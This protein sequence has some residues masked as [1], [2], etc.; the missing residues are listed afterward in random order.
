[1]MI[2]D[3]FELPKLPRR[4]RESAITAAIDDGI[5]FTA[6]R[7]AVELNAD[8]LDFVKFGWGS[9]LITK[10]LGQKI[11]VLKSNGIGFCVGG[12]M[13]E[14]AFFQGKLEP[15]IDWMDSIDATHFEISDGTIEIGKARK[16][17]LIRT[18]SGR[19][20]VL[21]EVGSKDAENVMTPSEYIREIGENSEAGCWKIILE[22][23][24]NGTVGIYD[25]TGKIKHD[26]LTVL[27][28]ATDIEQI[29]FEAPGVTQQAQLIEHFSEQ[30]NL[31]N[32]PL[33][34]TLNTQALRLGLR[35]DTFFLN[36]PFRR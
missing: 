27:G 30:V 18:L 22:A 6:F 9:S 10:T 4:P 3:L 24:Q 33:L 17:E 36:H 12:T 16:R 20:K 11:R 2:T 7:D 32:I 34:E 21:L 28:K 29:I 19:F 35:A 25:A 8:H 31:S 23:R 15:F 5:G 26:L 14:I 1:M 13:F